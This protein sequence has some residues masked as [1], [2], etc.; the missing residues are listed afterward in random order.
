MA[1]PPLFNSADLAEFAGAPFTE[2]QASRAAEDIRAEAGWHIAPSV[3]ETVV[4]ESDGGRYLFLDTLRLTAV[5][6][7]RDVTPDTPVVVTDYRTHATA[8]FRAG[9]L[10]RPGGWPVGVLEVDITHGYDE[11]PPTVLL[12]A[13]ALARE[14]RG[15]GA[16]G[17]VRLGSLAV[18]LPESTETV[19]GA[20]AR[21]KLPSRP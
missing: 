16:G 13:A 11:C 9:V 3:T 14:S 7:V 10:D 2:D 21:Y 8:R 17:S 20:V 18:T 12:A 19:G 1:T 4:M 15:G 6:E 5:S